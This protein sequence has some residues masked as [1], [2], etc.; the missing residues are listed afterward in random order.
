MQQV[1]DQLPTLRQSVVNHGPLAQTQRL[2]ADLK[3]PAFCLNN[4]VGC[5]SLRGPAPA[6]LPP[7]SDHSLL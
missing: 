5:V 2:L 4:T 6:S 1:R 3:V 7:L